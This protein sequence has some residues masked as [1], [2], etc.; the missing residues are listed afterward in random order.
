MTQ[1]SLAVCFF[2]AASLFGCAAE[3]SRPANALSMPSSSATSAPQTSIKN[4]DYPDKREIIRINIELG[5]VEMNHDDIPGVMPA[6][7]MEFYVS[8]KRMLTGLK[9][10]DAVDFTLR[11]KD[12]SET[13]VAIS[14]AK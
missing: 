12:R 8:D 2:T 9:A 4:G 14:K 10:V 6:M 11:Y 7:Q 13:I 1:K 3:H 5:S